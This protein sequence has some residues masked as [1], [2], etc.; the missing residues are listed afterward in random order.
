[1]AAK[2][3]KFHTE[4]REKMLRGV[5][6]L[7]NAVGAGK[8][9]RQGFRID[10][11]HDQVPEGRCARACQRSDHRIH[12]LAVGGHRCGKIRR[13]ANAGSGQQVAKVGAVETRLA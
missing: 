2:E 4:A 11:R 12:G 9:R 1:M 3:V 10:S 5:D 7:A 8:E 6:I 13:A